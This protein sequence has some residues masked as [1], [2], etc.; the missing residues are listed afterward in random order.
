VLVASRIAGAH[1]HLCLDGS[2]PPVSLHVADGA[3]HHGEEVGGFTHTDR[4]VNV[5]GEYLA[6]KP[7][8]GFDLALVAMAFGLLLFLLPRNRFPVPDY[9]CPHPARP[10]RAHGLPPPRG[11]PRLV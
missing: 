10:S 4:D 7:G 1:L 9:S 2:E 8:A 6:K 5:G 3:A 11:P